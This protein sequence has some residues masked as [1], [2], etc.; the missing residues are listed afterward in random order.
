MNFF[1]IC[2]Y[3]LYIYIL[4]VQSEKKDEEK[5][6]TPR[7]KDSDSHKQ[8]SLNETTDEKNESKTE[9]P[10][11]KEEIKDEKDTESKEGET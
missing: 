10:E 4:L 9:E 1:F 6:V 2:F 11:N 5:P 3:E 7:S 8:E